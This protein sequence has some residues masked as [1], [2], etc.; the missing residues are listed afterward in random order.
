MGLFYFSILVPVA[1]D[2]LPDFKASPTGPTQQ[3][4]PHHTCTIHLNCETTQTLHDAYQPCQEGRTPDRPMIEMCI[5]S[6]LDHTLAP[7]GCHVLS[8]F[9]QYTPY[10]LA[11]GQE[12]DQDAKDAYADK[13]E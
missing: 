11:D 10:H 12:W 1:V 6:S 13:G 2:R 4:G 7:E 5:P 3:P 8:L 9:T